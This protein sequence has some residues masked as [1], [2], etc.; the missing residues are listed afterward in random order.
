MRV[1][2]VSTND[3]ALYGY[4]FSRAL[5]SIGVD[6]TD[7]CRSPH[8]F[9]YSQESP[10]VSISEMVHQMKEADV[11]V[12]HHS[13]PQL[14]ELAKNNCKGKVIITHTGTRYRENHQALDILF[15]DTLCMSDQT[16]FFNINP[17]L[18]YLVSPVEFDLA[19]LIKDKPLKFAHYPSNAEVKGTAKIMELMNDFKGRCDFKVGTTTVDHYF[20][21]ERMAKCDVYIELFKPTLN[22]NPYGCFGVTALEAAGMGKLVITNNLYPKVYANAYGTCP[23]TYANTEVVFKNII[24]GILNMSVTAIKM[25][26]KETYEIM[27][28]NHSY[29]ST[30]KKIMSIIES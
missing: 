28:E 17:N 11:V 29:V 7:L 10:V 1:L 5:K 6:S 3:Y 19:P 16:E 23:M 20:Q 25:V 30:G 24:N 9:G 21:L 12:V 2:N 22:G 27:Q 13:D 14:F 8:P 18:H 15:K 4:N 26:Q